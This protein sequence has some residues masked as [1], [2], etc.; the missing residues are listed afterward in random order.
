MALGEKLGSF[1][2]AIVSFSIPSTTTVTILV[3]LLIFISSI[4]QYEVL[5]EAPEAS[6]QHGLDLSRAVRDLQIIAGRPHPFNSHANDGVHSHL[7][8]RVHEAS[9]NHSNVHI[10]DDIY[11]NATWGSSAGFGVYYEGNNILVKIDGEEPDLEAVLFSA[12]Y[13]SVSTA[14]GATDDGMGAVTLVQLVE[15]FAKNT[16]KR[17]VVFNINNG[18]EDGLNGA[19]V[20]MEHPWSSLP[21]L[22]LNLEGAGAGGR[23]MLFRTSSLSVTEAF[24]GV[25]HPHG[26][27]L[28]ADAFAT[29]LIRSATDYSI[30]QDAGIK[31]LD[32]AF[33]Q[34]RSLYHTKRDSVPSLDGPDALWIMMSSA[35]SSGLALTKDIPVKDDDEPAVYFDL[36]GEA[37]VIFALKTLFIVNVVLLVIG[38][39]LVAAGIALIY[40]RG[41]LHY[42]GSGWGRFPLSLILGFGLPIGLAYLYNVANPYIV[43]SSGYVVALSLLAAALIGLHLPLLI[44][45][46]FRPV[47]QQKSIILLEYYVLWWILLVFETVM[48]NKHKLGGLYAISFFHVAAFTAL[49]IT[50]SE[51]LVLPQKLHPNIHPT[52]GTDSGDDEQP[53]HEAVETERTPLLGRRRRVTNPNVQEGEHYGFWFAEYL[54]LVPFPVILVTN[55]CLTVLGSLPQSLADGS[56]PLTVY[57]ALAVLGFF[58]V[59]PLAPFAHKIHR[60]V[61]Y[62]LVVVLVITGAYNLLAFP[63]SHNSPLKVF[64]KQTI[65]LDDGTNAVSLTGVSGYINNRILP[66]LPSTVDQTPNCSASNIRLGLMTCEWEGLA[67]SILP[68]NSKDYI[69][70]NASLAAP[71]T[72]LI[73]LQGRNTRGCRIYFDRPV[74]TVRLENSTG[75]V[76]KLYPFPQDGINLL[77]LWSR[78]WDKEF[79]VTANWIGG[80]NLTGKVACGWAEG[81]GMS[82]L[83]E[84]S[85]FLPAWAIVSKFDDALVEAIHTFSV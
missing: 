71:G 31:G 78:E 21:K 75:A 43:Y 70:F 47:P 62:T 4:V 40:T 20:F 11:S 5:P 48:V 49:V 26:S 23:P 19:H 28:S 2:H 61:S 79:V 37:L 10:L 32:L 16:P 50:L 68:D 24:T 56:S 52:N 76:Q 77:K 25:T 13:D 3:Y 65:N 18:E 8:S 66:N 72:A 14:P 38:P 85:G 12:H 55:T 41:Q 67:P 83:D 1:G 44:L 17:T 39:L 29:G 58:V 81:G 73:K 33:Y 59:L 74:S 34:R 42:S 64:F 53:N 36:F 9:R 35:L 51:H 45:S 80:Q 46:E 82:A 30:Y 27:S 6:K 63:F 7:L 69:S 84:V 54:L 15:Y 22:F 60:Y 57:L